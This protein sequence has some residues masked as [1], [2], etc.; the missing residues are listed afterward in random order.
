MSVKIT[1]IIMMVTIL[2]CFGY[3]ELRYHNGWQPQTKIAM[4]FNPV[5]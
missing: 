3:G 2:V 5:A 1:C 4:E